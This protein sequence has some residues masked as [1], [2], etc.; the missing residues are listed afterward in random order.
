MK[1]KITADSTCDLSEELVKKYQIER[2]PLYVVAGEKN[3]RDALDINADKLYEMTEAGET[4]GTAAV[5]IHDYQEIFSRLRKEYD[6]IVHFTIS[7]DMSSC[8]QNACLAGEEVGE[9][10]VID[11]RNLSTGIGHLVVDAAIMA[12]EGYAP[13]EIK[14][15]LDEKK[16]RLDVS[17]V[18]DTMDYLRRGG[19]CSSIA[20]LGATML[21]LHPCI[22]V[23]QGKMGVGKKYRG[24]IEKAYR[25]YIKDALHDVEQ[26]DTERIFITH[27][28]RLEE[29]T[30]QELRQLVLSIAPFQEVLVTQAG[31][32]VSNHCGPKTM[33][34]LF[35]RK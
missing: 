19:R 21:K 9:V 12:Q 32:T 31:C 6:A 4:F 27:S 29:K 2:I 24:S 22:F 13:S 28:G 10:Y 8:Y 23:S 33:G 5:N 1:I 20:A 17:F 11:S 25:S 34:V 18:I 30:I 35:Y 14:K 3:F 16:E 26:I 15:H 7:A